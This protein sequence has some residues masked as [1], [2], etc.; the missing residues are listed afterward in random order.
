MLVPN[1]MVLSM[2]STVPMPSY[3]ANTASLMYG[4]RIRLAMNPGTSLEAVVSFFIHSAKWRVVARVVSLVCRAVMIS[5]SFITGTGFMKCI[6]ITWWARS[7]I[8]PAI[9]VNE[10]LEVLLARMACL[11]VRAAKSSNSLCLSFKSSEAASMT[12]STSVR[13]DL[14]QS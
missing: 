5:M 9:F 11:G 7:G 3:R 10:I 2:S 1:F 8:V 12:K 6:P 4:M 14:T 13:P